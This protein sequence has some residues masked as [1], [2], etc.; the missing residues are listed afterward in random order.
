MEKNTKTPVMCPEC[1]AITSINYSDK[2]D[3]TIKTL[4]PDS[5]PQELRINDK[6]MLSEYHNDHTFVVILEK[7]LSQDM[8]KVSEKVTPAITHHIL[9][10]I[11]KISLKSQNNEEFRILI[12]SDFLEWKLL[13]NQ[14]F[15]QLLQ[16]E[17][18]IQ[19]KSEYIIDDLKLRLRCENFGI[20]FNHDTTVIDHKFNVI[21]ATQKNII[22]HHPNFNEVLLNLE[23][24]GTLVVTINSKIEDP[25]P[26]IS[27]SDFN[28]TVTKLKLN[29]LFVD[30]HSIEQTAMLLTQIIP[31]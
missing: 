30:V 14:I 21:I 4:P 18:Y 20:Y 23:N 3:Y 11:D 19:L 24:K 28:D 27:M 13:L 2:L 25:V 17:R 31:K 15:S 1:R 7:D 22:S 10:I 29:F 16:D 8:L 26:K 9:S 5:F 12:L 6:I